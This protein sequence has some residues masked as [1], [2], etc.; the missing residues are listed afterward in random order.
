MNYEEGNSLGISEFEIEDIL[1]E[2]IALI[3]GV[4]E[5]H[6]T[7]LSFVRK[8]LKE[9]G[10]QLDFS[11]LIDYLVNAIDSADYDF[12]DPDTINLYVN[13]KKRLLQELGYDYEELKAERRSENDPYFNEYGE[14][15]RPGKEDSE[16]TVDSNSNGRSQRETRDSAVEEWLNGGKSKTPLQKREEEL[17]SLEKEAKKYDEEIKAHQAQREGQDKGE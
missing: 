1:S 3:A 6:P 12:L 16:Y 4:L 9:N 13:A 17:T 7:S 2:N 11:E 15:I 5:E 8:V 14:I 10:K